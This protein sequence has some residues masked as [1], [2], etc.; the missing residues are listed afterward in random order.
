MVIVGVLAFCVLIFVLAFVAPRLSRGPQRA[1]QSAM[2]FGVAWRV[3]SSR[4]AWPMVVEAVSNRLA[5]D[6]HDWVALEVTG[7]AWAIARILEPHVARVIVVSPS[8]TG[9]RQVTTWR[10]CAPGCAGSG[11]HGARSPAPPAR[12]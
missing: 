4:D 6:R 8:D 2:G 10:R 11:P 1:G 7:N 5:R 9:I 12:G 3:E